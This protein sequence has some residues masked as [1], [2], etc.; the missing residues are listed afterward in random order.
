MSMSDG[1]RQNKRDYQRGCEASRDRRE[2]GQ[3]TIT[4]FLV[5]IFFSENPTEPLRVNVTESDY[6][7]NRQEKNIYTQIRD[8]EEKVR[9][10][11]Y[12][13]NTNAA[14]LA[15]T[16]E[17][18]FLEAWNFP[19][20]WYLTPEFILRDLDEDGNSELYALTISQTDSLIISRLELSRYGSLESRSVCLLGRWNGEFQGLES[21]RVS[22]C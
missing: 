20:H 5:L 2:R 4:E 8:G 19:G 22:P 18:V 10:R 9:L 21:G 16:S 14:L 15:Y 13:L 11:A 3:A 17:G 7:G 12:N 6:H 1:V